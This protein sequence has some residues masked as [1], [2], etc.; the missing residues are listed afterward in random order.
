M[1]LKFLKLGIFFL[2]ITFFSFA[3]AAKVQ[4]VFKDIDSNYKYLDELQALYD[5]GMII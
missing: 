4:D 2:F 3:N 5:R 1:F